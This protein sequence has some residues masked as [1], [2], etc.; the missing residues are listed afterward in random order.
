MNHAEPTASGRHVGQIF[1]QRAAELGD[2]TFIKL[3][4]G[5]CFE[6]I[7][8]GEFAA[9]VSHALLGLCALGILP[10]D[11]VAIIGENSLEWLA[12]DMA[13]LAGGFTNV[14]IAPSLSDV[15]FAKVLGHAGCRAAFVQDAVTQPSG[16]V[17]GFATLVGDGR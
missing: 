12:A 5:E 7:S 2:R 13:T 15:M 11:T 9:L 10:G 8:W 14:V 6:E 4:K 16:A 1:F 3:Q 17:A